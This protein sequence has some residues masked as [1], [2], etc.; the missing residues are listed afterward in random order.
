MKTTRRNFGAAALGL[1]AG[2]ALTGRI[3][4]AIAQQDYPTRPVT[5]VVPFAAGG[6]SDFVGRLLAEQLTA[7]LGQQFL[8]D[9]R[10][11]ASGT[12]GSN[13]VARAEPD[14]HTLL[15]SPNST[16]SMAPFLYDSLP[17]DNAKAFAP[18]GLIAGNA[19]FVCV[20][21]EYEAK[22]LVELITLAKAKPGEISFGSGGVGVS[23]H[24]AVELFQEAAG[25]ELLHVPYKGGAPAVTDLLGGQIQLSFVDAV[26]AIPHLRS[27]KLRALA[28]TSAQRNGLAPEVPTIAEAGPIPGY[29][30]STDFGLFAPAGTPEPVIRRLSEVSIAALRKQDVKDRL[31][32]LAIDPIGGTPEE[33]AAYWAKEDAKWGEIIRRRNIHL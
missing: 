22:T 14:G 32:Q 29:Q 26:T 1:T 8:V 23:N 16:F 33:F 20:Q 28:V 7:A 9:N 30:A 11:G 12:I 27:G 4:P 31:A 21:P 10:P 17:Y 18:I 6:S 15:L 19:M 2:A 3:R 24:L 5:I 25:I 13:N